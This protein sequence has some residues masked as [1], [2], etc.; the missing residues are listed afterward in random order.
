MWLHNFF[1]KQKD[2][3]IEL[4][5]TEHAIKKDKLD[6]ANRQLQEQAPDVRAETLKRLYNSAKDELNLLYAE[7]PKTIH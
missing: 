6:E 3:T 1:S 4:L 7:N 2:A 5:K